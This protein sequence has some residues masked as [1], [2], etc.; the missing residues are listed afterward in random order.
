[1]YPRKPNKGNFSASAF[2][3]DVDRNN[4]WIYVDSHKTY[5]SA[6]Y[7]IAVM[8]IHAH[9]VWTVSLM[10]LGGESKCISLFMIPN[11]WWS[12]NGCPRAQ[13]L[14]RAHK[15]ADIWLVRCIVFHF[16]CV[17]ECLG[18]R[19]KPRSVGVCLYE[20]VVGRFSF[21]N[22]INCSCIPFFRSVKLRPRANIY[23]WRRVWVCMKS[24]P[25]VIRILCTMYEPIA[26]ESCV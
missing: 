12:F 11:K 25:F 23:L 4:V 26:L 24:V 6:Q 5:F 14:R 15:C 21:S 1:M 3:S 13:Q 20:W 18:A 9:N 19:I 2:L 8:H 16:E 7:R 10:G 22:R 17:F